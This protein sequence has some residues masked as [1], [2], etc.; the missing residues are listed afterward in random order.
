M[1]DLEKYRELRKAAERATPGP[2]ET[3]KG[4]ARS[5]E[6]HGYRLV[7][8]TLKEKRKVY[9]LA[10]NMW[11]DK[12]GYQW[13]DDGSFIAAANP[14]VILGLLDLL[15]EYEQRRKEDSRYMAA[16]ST[17]LHEAKRNAD[18]TDD[19][20]TDEDLLKLWKKAN[21]SHPDW[22]VFGLMVIDYG[23]VV[24]EAQRAKQS[25][26]SESSGAAKAVCALKT[27]PTRDKGGA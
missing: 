11:I 16:L 15:A 21:G 4:L 8:E 9:A 12:L 20:L 22:G 27:A 3:V 25:T 13:G 5:Y 2:W 10:S 26:P 23:R 18:T 17:E 14:A 24:L 19:M 1:S 6:D 7:C